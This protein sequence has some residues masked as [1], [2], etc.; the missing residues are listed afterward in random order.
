MHSVTSVMGMMVHAS[1]TQVKD[2]LNIQGSKYAKILKF[3]KINKYEEFVLVNLG[4]LMVQLM[5]ANDNMLTF[6][7]II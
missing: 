7:C 6:L 5:G 2:S 4:I 3:D 1:K